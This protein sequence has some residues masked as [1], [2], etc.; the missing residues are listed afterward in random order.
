MDRLLPLLLF[1]LP[2]MASTCP[3]SDFPQPA[4]ITTPHGEITQICLHIAD[5]QEMRKIGLQPYTS[6]PLNHGML[7]RF[8]AVSTSAFWMKGTQLPL[9]IAFIDDRGKIQ[10]ITAMT[11][12]RQSPCRQYHAQSPYHAALEMEAGWFTQHNIPLNSYLNIPGKT[13][14]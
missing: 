7:F 12:C 4:Q 1:P 2:L 8:P 9:S 6:L 10:Q 14:N 13:L 11:L 3:N 5:T